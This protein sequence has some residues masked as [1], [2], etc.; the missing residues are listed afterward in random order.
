MHKPDLFKHQGF[1]IVGGER[2]MLIGHLKLQEEF[3]SYEHILFLAN[4]WLKKTLFERNIII[5]VGQYDYIFRSG[6][7]MY[8]RETYTT[9][10]KTWIL[11]NHNKIIKR[12]QL[13]V[14][15][16]KNQ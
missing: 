2:F 9:I 10:E 5:L 14:N 13:L 12:P 15:E 1:A 4:N 7:H 8:V 6:R 3:Y 11:F 16:K